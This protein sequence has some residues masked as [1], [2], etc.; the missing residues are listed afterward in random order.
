VPWQDAAA[1]V[2]EIVTVEGDVAAV[3][4]V[5]GACILEFARDDPAA[6]RVVLVLG[7]FSS[8]DDP[9]GLYSGHHV[10]VSGRVQRFQGR[11]EMIVRRADQIELADAP[12]AAV[13]PP[14][15]ESRTAPP[16]IAPRPPAERPPRAEPMPAPVAAPD[17]TCADSRATRARAA[18]ELAARTSALARCL[19]RGERECREERDAARSALD[20]L[21]A[22]EQQETASCR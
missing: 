2:G 18:R 4:V 19:A 17:A 1:H 12:S 10:R 20:A 22:G 21:D 6:L 5:P 14:V 8:P 7:L 15:R 16:P 13:P 3:R 11:P 9:E